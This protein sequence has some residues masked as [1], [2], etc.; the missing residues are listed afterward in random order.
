MANTASRRVR[1]VLLLTL[2]TMVGEIVVGLWSGSMA[3]LADG[4]HMGTHAA[5]FAVTLF[6]YHYAA[7]H[8]NNPAFIFGTGKVNDLGGF[9]SAIALATVALMMVVESIE[10][11]FNATTIHYEQAMIAAAIGLV[12][13]LLSVALL[14]QHDH[15]HHHDHD[16]EPLVGQSEHGHNHHHDQNLRAAFFHVLADTLTSVLA[17]IALLTGKLIGWWWLDPLMGIVGAI[18]IAFWAR[19]LIKSTASVLLDQQIQSQQADVREW[20]MGGGKVA[21]II[22]LDRWPETSGFDST[23]KSQADLTLFSAQ[24]PHADL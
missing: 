10:R 14:H 21:R 11:L 24:P 19:S 9:A 16:H 23:A 12:V 6:A 13:N 1:W 22:H 20:S 5:A 8:T 7:K 15:E 3:L 18:V 17:I 2:F 4:W